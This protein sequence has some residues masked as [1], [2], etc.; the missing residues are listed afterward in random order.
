MHDEGWQ[1]VQEGTQDRVHANE[2]WMHA[3]GQYTDCRKGFIL[4][5]KG[6]EEKE[7]R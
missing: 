6:K 7:L 3:L 2:E 4:Q 1:K 5:G